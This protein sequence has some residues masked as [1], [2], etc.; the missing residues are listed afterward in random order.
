MRNNQI[1][2]DVIKS[3]KMGRNCVVLTERTAHVEWLSKNLSKHISD[4]NTLTGGMGTKETREV[5]KR[6]AETPI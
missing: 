6:I 2:E 3:H 4:V 1:V 5:M